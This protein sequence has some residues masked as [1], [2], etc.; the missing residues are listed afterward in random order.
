MKPRCS[1]ADIERTVTEFLQLDGWR[2]IHTDPCSDRR[3]AKGFGEL[4][5]ADHLYIRYK[6][7]HPPLCD[8]EHFRPVSEVLWIEFKAPGKKPEPH[9]ARWHDA[10]RLRGALVMVVDDIDKFTEW[11]KSS[12][13]CRRILT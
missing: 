6:W 7:L 1:E 2:A 8:K 4:G 9:Q 3:R 13:L 10:E 12:G 11:Y 5:M